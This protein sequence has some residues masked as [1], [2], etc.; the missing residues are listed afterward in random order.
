MSSLSTKFY[1]PK[2]S[3]VF[4]QADLWDFAKITVDRTPKAEY[5][6]KRENKCSSQKGPFAESYQAASRKREETEKT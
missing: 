5:A 1:L 4:W 3:E 6:K 2:I